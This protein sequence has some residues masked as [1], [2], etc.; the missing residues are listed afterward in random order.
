MILMIVILIQAV[1]IQKRIMT[2][3][4]EVNLNHGQDQEGD[5]LVRVLKRTVKLMK[6]IFRIAK[7]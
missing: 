6:L 1:T 5:R 7:V 4:L 2:L 3:N